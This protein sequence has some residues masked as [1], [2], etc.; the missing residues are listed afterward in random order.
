MPR[1][2][3]RIHSKFH[4]AKRRFFI[5]LK[6]QHIYGVLNVD[7]IKKLITQFCYTLRDE[8]FEPN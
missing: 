6:Y 4:Y 5:T 3:S 8:H 2:D 1:L 7:E